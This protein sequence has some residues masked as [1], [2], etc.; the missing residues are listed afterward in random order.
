MK[1]MVWLLAATMLA[2]SILVG[3]QFDQIT[4]S[5]AVYRA[6]NLRTWHQVICSIETAVIASKAP[7]ARKIAAVKFY[8]RLLEQIHA[9]PCGVVV[10]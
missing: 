5:R 2:L 7:P 10:K 4:T 6:Q 3:Y 8:D 9:A 1:F